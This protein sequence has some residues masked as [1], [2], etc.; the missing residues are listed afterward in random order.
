MKKTY[1]I[2]DAYIIHIRDYDVFTK[3]NNNTHVNKNL[4]TADLVP[5]NIL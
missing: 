4:E 5:P 2:Y 1:V 3:A